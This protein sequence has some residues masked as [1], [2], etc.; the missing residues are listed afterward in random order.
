MTTITTSATTFT[1]PAYDPREDETYTFPAGT[2]CIYCQCEFS[3][4]D[5]PRT[6]SG[7]TA[8]GPM[9]SG[10]AHKSD[11]ASTGIAIG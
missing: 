9:C 4:T 10:C 11:R 6:I 2:T 7:V 5:Y 3:A 8:R 1:M